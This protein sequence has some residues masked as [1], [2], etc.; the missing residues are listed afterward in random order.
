MKN[1]KTYILEKNVT[2]DDVTSFINNYYQ[3]N[4]LKEVGKYDKETD[5]GTFFVYDD[6]KYEVIEKSGKFI[7][8]TNCGIR[9]KRSDIPHLTGGGLF[10][11]GEVNS[12]D[13]SRSHNIK[14]LEGAPNKCE[15]FNC[16]G[17]NNI[18]S[19]KGCPKECK[20]FYCGN[21]KNL[22]S[23]EGSPNECTNFDCSECDKLTS[24]NGSP[25]KVLGNFICNDC[26]SLKSLKGLPDIIEGNLMCKGCN[27]KSTDIYPYNKNVYC[28]IIYLY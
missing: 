12:F 8:N 4:G 28:D 3:S 22:K 26:H 10:E 2:I 5:S 27:F 25:K 20:Y 21:C 18:K 17:C 15:I 1:L 24:L 11:W 7:V 6:L 13:C 9:T 23:L 19:L 16:I 14:T